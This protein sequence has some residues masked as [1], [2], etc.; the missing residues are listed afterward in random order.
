M[1]PGGGG[2]GGLQVLSKFGW[3]DCFIRGLWLEKL[4]ISSWLDESVLLLD[5]V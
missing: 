3:E 5:S 2:G 4:S 1:A